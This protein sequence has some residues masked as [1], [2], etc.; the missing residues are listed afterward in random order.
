[1]KTAIVEGLAQRIADGDVPPKL[2]NIEIRSLDLAA[3]IAGARFRGDF[4]ERLKKLID[5]VLKNPN[6]VLFI[7]EAHTLVG[8]GASEGSMDAANALKPHLA[9]GEVRMIGATTV[10]EYRKRFE[11]DKA[12]VRRFQP[13]EVASPSPEDAI[14]ILE[15][16]APKYEEFHGV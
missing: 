10:D 6:V 3:L 13:V 14:T 11:K 8:A 5:E 7:D 16:I 9:R 15:G 4:E 1:G 12:L 2:Q